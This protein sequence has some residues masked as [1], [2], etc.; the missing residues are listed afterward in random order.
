ML[1]IYIRWLIIMVL[2]YGFH[3]SLSFYWDVGLS[4][5]DLGRRLIP[6]SPR[7]RIG[8]LVICLNLR[9]LKVCIKWLGWVKGQFPIL[10]GLGIVHYDWCHVVSINLC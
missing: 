10:V 9:C 2:I 7:G 1:Y 6:E 3:I 8:Y 4:C 5:V